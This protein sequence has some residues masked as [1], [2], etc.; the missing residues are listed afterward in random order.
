MKNPNPSPLS[1]GRSTAAG[2][3][4]RIVQYMISDDDGAIMTAFVL[5]LSD[6]EATIEN[7]GGKGMSLAKLTRAGLPVP[8][9][10]HLTT[11]AYRALLSA[12]GL[13]SKILEALKTADPT[14]QLTLD[15]ASRQIASLFA[16]AAMPAEIAAAIADAI[17]R[18]GDVP[19]AVRSSATAEDLPNASF[20]GQQ[21]TYLN[22]R[23]AAAATE[24]VK[25]CWAS[26]W[27][28]RA[29]S[30][31]MKNGI[32]QETVALAV[33]VQ[34]LIPA[35]AAGVLFTANPVSGRREEAMI[36][37]AWGLGEAIVS[38]AV[39][40]DTLTIDKASS[41]MISRQIAEKRVMTVRTESGTREEAVPDS[42]QKKPVLSRAQASELVHLGVEIESLYGTPMDVEWALAHG[43]FFILQ[44]R[45][46][47]SLP[48]PP[49]EWVCPNPKAILMRQSFA[50][51]IPNPVS[52]LFATLAVPIASRA[53]RKVFAEFLGDMGPNG[54]FFSL[55]N[56][57]VYL[58]TVLSPKIIWAIIV[59]AVK[60]QMQKML[61]T[62]QVR[63]TA[64]STRYRN[65]VA[66]WQETNP[67]LLSARQ[68]LQAAKEIF[69]GAAEYY[70]VAQSGPIP[71]ASSSELIFTRFY[72]ALVK[73]KGDPTAA[74]FLLALDSLPLR[75]EKAL[76]DLAQ[77]VGSQPDLE[78]TIAKAHAD[79]ICSAL[80]GG[81]LPEGQDRSWTDFAAR[82][83]SYLAEYGH[84]VFDLDFAKPVPADDPRPQ[85]EAIKACL[86]G[87]G[88]DPYARQ[89]ATIEKREQ[90]I[91]EIT[92][93]LGR[94]RRKWFLKLLRR[95]QDW[96]PKREDCISELGWGYPLL[97]RLFAE[98]GRRLA[99]GGAIS[100][101]G[102]VYWLEAQEVEALVA[103]LDAGEILPNYLEQASRRKAKVERVRHVT[104]PLSLPEKTWIS[105]L[106]PREKM[107]RNTLKGIGA[108]GGRVTARACV[109]H[110]PQ[111]FRKMHPGDVIVAVT[112]TP[113]W[114]PLFVMASAVV[115]E[116]GGPLSHSSIVAREFGI[117][118]V[119]ATGSATHRIQSGQIITV[120]GNLG[121]VLIADRGTLQGENKIDQDLSD[122][123]IQP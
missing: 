85:L 116:I 92:G 114:T 50:E 60:G 64:V 12:N 43:K 31:R 121:T 42:I 99:A 91:R 34:V 27:T 39:T 111:D 103:A 57:Y 107:E 86:A 62:G 53:T 94:I 11:R 65:I 123:R 108:S 113:A 19:L 119:L 30:Y 59:A 46:I 56:N 24:A 15:A 71:G 49:L 89:H 35:E 68:L 87:K 109:L 88:S 76:F 20:A 73:R 17:P 5:P 36:T 26:L 47:T 95:A 97:R 122:L 55:I 28:A 105:K 6:L 29:I 37:A 118:A 101:P 106:L 120:D 80:R 16:A 84:T 21:E 77:W 2:I 83:G 1:A 78:E 51:F 74:E 82:F 7:V 61:K 52:P 66:R 79:E 23:G 38:G 112:T 18:L 33:V 40:P 115:T 70:T 93:R 98:L 96:A 90:A 67:A 104:V 3:Q 32:D 8:N 44:A 10:F 75:A 22:I 117:P 45:P 72:S 48:E 102:D 14:D 100:L 41:R 13:E 58:G 110:D 54:I 81:I 63:W 4:P 9:G 69:E 25:R